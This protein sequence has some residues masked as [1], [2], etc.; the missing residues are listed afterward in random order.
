MSSNRKILMNS[1]TSNSSSTNSSNFSNKKIPNKLYTKEIN[2]LIEKII[3]SKRNTFRLSKLN[4]K[5]H[6]NNN[7]NNNNH[8]NN[9]LEHSNSNNEFKNFKLKNSQNNNNNKSKSE[10]E[11]ILNDNS[12]I[13]IKNN[14]NQKI[15]EFSNTLTFY[16]NLNESPL[17]ASEKTKRSNFISNLLKYLKNLKDISNF[18]FDNDNLLLQI[19]N[20]ITLINFSHIRYY[21][22]YKITDSSYNQIEE[23]NI[24]KSTIEE[25]ALTENDNAN[26]NNANVIRIKNENWKDILNLYEILIILLNNIPTESILINKIP[27]N[28]I[29]NLIRALQTLDNEE[30][31]IIKMIIY[32]IYICSLTYRKFILKNLS[33]IIVDVT[34]FNGNLYCL[35]ECLDLLRVIILGAKKPVNV[36][37]INCVN[38]VILPLL[39]I[40]GICKKEN[41]K[42]FVFKLMAFDQVVLENVVK[43]IIKTWPIRFPER[44]IVYLEIIENL[45]V[46]NN[47]NNNL[48]IDFLPSDLS[49]VIFKKIKNCFSD[50]SFLIAD[51]SLIFYKNE[52]FMNSLNKYKLNKM[53]LSKLIENIEKHWSQEIKIISKIIITRLN[54]RDEKILNNLNEKEKKILNDFKFDINDSEDIWDIHFNLKGD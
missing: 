5:N 13:S 3:K 22:K 7:N 40:K 50:L 29:T 19:F 8:N 38:T 23:K 35:N 46:D 34:Y 20:L 6:N 45:F 11:S 41:L 39:K 37:Y 32:K 43:F 14:N 9:E 53:F 15:L 26:N 4:S 48:L 27:L 12:N 44:I 42:E 28:F 36:K 47:N 30:R 52:N 54:K 17:T 24:S 33:E 2:S 16:L 1:N 18:I 21:P 10:N 31:I 49:L 51:R 25:I